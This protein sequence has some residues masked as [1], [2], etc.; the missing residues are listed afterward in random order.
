M[1][2]AA[3][4][5]AKFTE[6]GLKVNVADFQDIVYISISDALEK[7]IA[8]QGLNTVSQYMFGALVEETWRRKGLGTLLKQCCE[9]IA[10]QKGMKKLISATH[11]NNIPMQNLM[12]K[13]GYKRMIQYSKDIP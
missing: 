13:M 1:K 7:P 12:E 5:E 9:D 11:P 6:L 3:S 2:V 10:R 8:Y 4:L